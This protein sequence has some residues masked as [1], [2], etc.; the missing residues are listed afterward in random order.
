M[1][2]QKEGPQAANLEPEKQQRSETTLARDGIDLLKGLLDSELGKL[3]PGTARRFMTPDH[4]FLVVI[5]PEI[6]TLDTEWGD[7]VRHLEELVRLQGRTI[8]RLQLRARQ[9][10]LPLVP[11]R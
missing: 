3:E 8:E 5:D 10:E 4:S 1:R 2:S 6:K 7:P 11:R 9:P